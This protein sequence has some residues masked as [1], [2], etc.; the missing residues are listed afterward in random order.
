MRYLLAVL[1][2][3]LAGTA[4]ADQVRDDLTWMKFYGE[5]ASRCDTTLRIGGIDMFLE[6]D[7]CVAVRERFDEYEKRFQRLADQAEEIDNRAEGDRELRR[8]VNEAMSGIDSVNK[9]A[10]RMNYYAQ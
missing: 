8:L 4:A 7:D 5:Q 3:G 6:S 2:L 10:E 1:I 9:L